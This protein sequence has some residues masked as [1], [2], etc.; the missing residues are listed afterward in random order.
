M[1]AEKYIRCQSLVQQFLILIA[2]VTNRH[3]V[4]D[5]KIGLLL[6]NIQAVRQIIEG[7]T[8]YLRCLFLIPQD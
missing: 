5:L 4:P 8:F 3:D 7:K 6:A 1:D 2:S